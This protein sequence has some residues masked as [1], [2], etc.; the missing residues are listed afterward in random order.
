MNGSGKHNLQFSYDAA[1]DALQDFIRTW[2][3]TEFNARDY[4]VVEG[5]WDKA[6]AEREAMSAKIREIRDYL[7]A[8]REHL[9]S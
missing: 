6:L 1:N 9:Y 7:N 3:N 4:Y 5:A 2:G 8:I